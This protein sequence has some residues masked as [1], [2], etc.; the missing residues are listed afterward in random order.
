[1]TEI[2]KTAVLV[3]ERPVDALSMAVAL[4][5]HV[6]EAT[7]ASSGYAPVPAGMA[8]IRVAESHIEMK[9]D[10]DGVTFVV[11][12]NRDL[13]LLGQALSFAGE[14]LLNQRLGDD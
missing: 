2:N 8:H 10:K 13:A 4:D 5:G 3:D 12:D 11:R 14:T 7:A 1:M 6:V 9:Q